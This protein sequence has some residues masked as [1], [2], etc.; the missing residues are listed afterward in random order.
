[1][2]TKSNQFFYR[3]VN[4]DNLFDPALISFIKEYLIIYVN[5]NFEELQ[6]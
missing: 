1:M 5:N 3:M 6:I 4:S 2:I